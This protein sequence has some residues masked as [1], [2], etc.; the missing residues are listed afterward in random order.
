MSELRF[1]TYFMEAQGG[2]PGE[3]AEAD[4]H[5]RSGEQSQ[6]AVGIR[7]ALIPFS[8]GWF[9]LRRSTTNSGRDPKVPEA[10]AVVPAARS[11]LVGVPGTVEGGE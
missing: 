1:R 3:G 10:Q 9:V 4:D 11:R 7:E 2:A 6:L 5:P 8:G